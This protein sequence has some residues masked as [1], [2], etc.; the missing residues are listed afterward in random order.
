MLTTD[1][2]MSVDGTWQALARLVLAHAISP[3]LVKKLLTWRHPGFSAQVGESIPP[4]D[5]LRLCDTAAYLVRDPLF[6][7][8]GRANSWPARTPARYGR[9]RV[10]LGQVGSRSFDSPGA[11]P[12]GSSGRHY[13]AES[14]AVPAARLLDTRKI[15]WYSAKSIRYN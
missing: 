3:E 4:T 12:S 11:R 6:W 8:A 2:A 5:K 1:G 9:G 13:T 15:R 7:D 10:S 14:S